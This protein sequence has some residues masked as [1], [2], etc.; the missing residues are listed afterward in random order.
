MRDAVEAEVRT[1][2]KIPYPT[3]AAAVNYEHS[4]GMN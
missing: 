1:R 3:A 2:L 4:M